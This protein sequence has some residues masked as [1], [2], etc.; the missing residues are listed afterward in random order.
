MLRG[1]RGTGWCLE[2][3]SSSFGDGENLAKGGDDFFRGVQYF[4]LSIY[5]EK[6]YVHDRL[7]S[8]FYRYLNF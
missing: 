4:Y 8:F 5:R 7:Y 1:G 2:V 3:F 6:S